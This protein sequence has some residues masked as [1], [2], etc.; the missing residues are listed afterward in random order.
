MKTKHWIGILSVV[1]LA[2]V[3]VGANDSAARPEPVRAAVCDVHKAMTTYK[4]LADLR[5]RMDKEEKSFKEE[6]KRRADLV[7]Q[8]LKQLGD[9]KKD[10]ADYQKLDQ[11]TWDKMYQLRVYQEVEQNKLDRKRRDG[12]QACYED[13]LSEISL[14]C[15]ENGVDLVEYISPV[16]LDTARNVQELESLINSRR[17]LFNSSKIDISDTMAAR[18][19]AKYKASGAPL[20]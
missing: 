20:K 14:Y 1:L 5:D 3:L 17:V 15:Q 16:P 8:M 6:G 10:S 7:E 13:L 12:L 2:A 11:E 18:L 19:N 4:R 9:L